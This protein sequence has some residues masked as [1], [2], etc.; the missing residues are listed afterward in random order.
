MVWEVI[1]NYSEIWESKKYPVN[2]IIYPSTISGKLTVAS[3]KSMTQRA[4]AAG[5]MAEGTMIIRN[6]SLCDDS[7]SAL[8]VASGLGAITSLNEEL[9]SFHEGKVPIESLLNCGES[10]LG[11]RLFS[12]IAALSGEKITLTGEGS[13]LK[14]PMKMIGDALSQLGVKV[15]TENG[16]LPIS[17]SGKLRGGLAIIDG[18]TG[19]QVLSGL[20]MALPV[21]ARDSLIRVDNLKSKPYID[22]TIELLF[23]FGIEIRHDNYIEFLIPGN[24]QYISRDY[25][26]EGD[27]SSAAFLLAGGLI[28]G[29]VEVSGLNCWSKQADMAILK[30]I[31]ATGNGVERSEDCYRTKAG[32]MKP[33]TFDASDSPDLFPPLA[34]MAAYC[35]GEST[36]YGVKR[37]FHK[38]SDR[39]E[40]IL[41]VLNALGIRACV[42]EDG[43]NV[44]GGQ[45]RGGRVQSHHDHRIAMMATIMALRASGP[46]I[47]EDAGCVA[48]SYPGFFK[49]IENLGVK[50]TEEKH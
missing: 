34:C 12:P 32:D 11:I 6:P 18:S 45:V 33:F 14:R 44:Y 9:I 3:S 47:I 24:Q 50:T 37:L 15:H 40:T 28:N 17:L 30:A 8:R 36:I 38:E 26:V 27:W 29:D 7:M 19:S 39:A 48:K 42:K 43:M 5:L 20:L 13:L 49:D 31:Q 21:T 35:S 46:V 10:G 41:E 16:F 4:I 2:Q 22:M 25:A 23:H 1:G